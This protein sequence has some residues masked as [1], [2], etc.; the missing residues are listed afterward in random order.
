MVECNTQI[1]DWCP[2]PGKGRQHDTIA[3]AKSYPG[4]SPRQENNDCKNGIVRLVNFE[5]PRDYL[6]ALHPKF[7]SYRVSMK[8]NT[9]FFSAWQYVTLGTGFCA[10][11]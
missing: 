10:C 4:E 8:H 2:V 1:T 5:T 3:V 6:K 9:T 11:V 7:V